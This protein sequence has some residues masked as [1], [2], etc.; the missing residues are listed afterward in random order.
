MYPSD[1]DL[2]REQS[3]RSSRGSKPKKM[4]SD[5]FRDATAV[6]D[7]VDERNAVIYQ[8]ARDRE[9]NFAQRRPNVGRDP[10][11]PEWIYETKSVRR[12]LYRLPEVKAAIAFKHPI[13]LVEGEKDADNL[14]KLGLTA[15]T[16]A[17][18]AAARWLPDY[19]EQLKGS[20]EVI[21]VPDNDEPGLK[22]ARAVRKPLRASSIKSKT[23][24]LPGLPEGGDVSDWIDT[25]GTREQLL[26]LS[27]SP[28]ELDGWVSARKLIESP[29][30]DVDWILTGYLSRP[31][32]AMLSGD[33]G[34]WKSWTA[35]DLSIAR[36]AGL[37]FLGH[38]SVGP[39]GRVMYITA[40][41]DAAEVRR[42]ISYLCAGARLTEEQLRAL[43]QNLKLWIGDLDFSNDEQFAKLEE[44]VA[45][46]QPE[47]VIVDHI[48]VC[49]EG[50]ES[51]SMFA[52]EVKR[53]ARALIAAHPCCVLW[54]HHWRKQAKEREM[55][56]AR[57]RVRGTGGLVAICDHHLSIERS[58]DGVATFIVD[59]NR[60]GREP[61]P[62]DFVPNIRE[63]DG[64]AIL[65][66][67]G[68]AAKKAAESAKSQREKVRA[69]MLEA[70]PAGIDEVDLVKRVGASRGTVIGHRKT[71]GALKVEGSKPVRYRLA[72]DLSKLSESGHPDN[73]TLFNE[74]DLG[75]RA[76]IASESDQDNR[77][78]MS[79]LS[80]LKGRPTKTDIRP[81]S[82][83]ADKPLTLP[84]PS[85]ATP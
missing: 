13:Y 7:Y 49:F 38:F 75:G 85:G 83:R 24:R 65:E 69:V 42:K 74:N 2:D 68:E 34:V 23:L 31:S 51:S 17:M 63:S 47:L 44:D 43:D 27:K 46:F 61:A 57:Q 41:E 54:H 78:P 5:I 3:P 11:E 25:G 20:C 8:V 39:P 29:I 81:V 30:K 52:R 53:R 33:S 84:H 14:A 18:G 6:Y 22:R 67:R 19:T 71:L 80:A 60:K 35:L 16:A 58:K 48:R 56:T 59:K 66:Y 72:S 40:D 9:K 1:Q 4:P 70:G 64:T 37:G 28:P 73:A 36:A 82:G 62:F 21:V 12:V 15:T 77:C 79:E 55:N 10:S 45:N 76:S 50:E 26:Q 32:T